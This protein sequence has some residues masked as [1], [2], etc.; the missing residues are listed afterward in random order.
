MWPNLYS[1]PP[2]IRR[3]SHRRFKFQAPIFDIRSLSSTSTKGAESRRSALQTFDSRQ[4]N[5]NLN[6]KQSK[7]F[8]SLLTKR[9]H[10]NSDYHI[11]T[12]VVNESKN[13]HPEQIPPLQRG[14][15]HPAIS[16]ARI[17]KLHHNVPHQLRQMLPML[18]QCILP[19][20]RLLYRFPK[21]QSKP[22][23]LDPH[24]NDPAIRKHPRRTQPNQGRHPFSNRIQKRHQRAP[25]AQ[26]PEKDM[27]SRRR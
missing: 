16:S 26:V 1:S 18:L 13:P 19:P 27:R 24:P 22:T 15:Q 14:P 10:L 8:S 17:G 7:Q 9:A 25:I 12:P 4:N 11:T 2:Y 20:T 6:F 23:T 5:Q 21:S 3:P